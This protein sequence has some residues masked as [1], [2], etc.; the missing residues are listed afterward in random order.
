MSTHAPPSRDDG[1]ELGRELSTHTILFHQAVA[2]RLGLNLSDHKCLDLIFRNGPMTAGQ[3]ATL[4]GLTTGAITG[5]IDR[6][7]KAGFARRVRAPNDRRKV[8]VEADVAKAHQEIAPLF[9]SLG[10]AMD[11]LYR[12][13]TPSERAVIR[14]FTERTIR[15]LKEE[16]ERLAQA[17]R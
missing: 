12:S 13:Y 4:S 8:I 16:A 15:I 14:D 2:D 9:T 3:L 1:I 6:L 11:D 10:R 5:V 7:E 17:D